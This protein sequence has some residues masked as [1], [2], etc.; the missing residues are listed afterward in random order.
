MVCCL[1]QCT[2]CV[3]VCAFHYIC[4]PP[5]D[6]QILWCTL[7]FEEVFHWGDLCCGLVVLA[8]AAAKLP[9][10]DIRAVCQRC[11]DFA[12][13]AAAVTKLAVSVTQS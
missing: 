9:C 4:F 1:R 3:C 11:V 12:P 2:G 6:L 7:L 8:A 13:E 5:T 10:A